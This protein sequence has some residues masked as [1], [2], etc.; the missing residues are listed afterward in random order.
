VGA[1]GNIHTHRTT[2]QLATHA[3]F[4]EHE[5]A[6]LAGALQS[7]L[8]A[9]VSL[10]PQNQL[11]RHVETLAKLTAPSLASACTQAAADDYRLFT[12]RLEAISELKVLLRTVLAD[13]FSPRLVRGCGG[14]GG[15][16]VAVVAV[17]GGGGGAW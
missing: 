15:G 14:G 6:V 10:D 5:P 12:G 2:V 17:G 13:V 1:D 4:D 8:A 11:Q 3:A 9:A 16:R 7:T